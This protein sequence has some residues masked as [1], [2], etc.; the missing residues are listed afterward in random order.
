MPNKTLAV[1]VSVL[2]LVTGSSAPSAETKPDNATNFQT[3]AYRLP[4]G[5]FYYIDRFRDHPFLRPKFVPGASMTFIATSSEAIVR[6]TPT[7]HKE[8]RDFV[9]RA[10]Q[11]YQKDKSAFQRPLPPPNQ[12]AIRVQPNGTVFIGRKRY[13]LAALDSELRRQLQKRPTISVAL[14]AEPKTESKQFSAGYDAC[15]KAGIKEI[16]VPYDE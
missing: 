12:I 5:W 13:T 2:W 15:T 7:R 9:D 10:W 1:A 4:P 16:W 14:S 6:D 8:I 11:L 3:E